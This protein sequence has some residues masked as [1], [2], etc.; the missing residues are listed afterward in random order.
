[1]QAVLKQQR[2]IGR[3]P[4]MQ[5][6]CTSA[7]GA[8][9]EPSFT[10]GGRFSGGP[11]E[12]WHDALAAQH[13][14]ESPAVHISGCRTEARPGMFAG[15]A[16]AWRADSGGTLP[17]RG[18]AC[19]PAAIPSAVMQAGE[20][21]LSLSQQ[22][23][24]RDSAESS[25]ATPA[26]AAEGQSPC[27]EPET[28]LSAAHAC[29]GAR[30]EREETPFFTPMAAI[31]TFRLSQPAA[32]S[33]AT[34]SN[35][36]RPFKHAC[37]DNTP[38]LSSRGQMSAAQP[39]SRLS[40]LSGPYGLSLEG[41][42]DQRTSLA[43]RGDSS[44]LL[45]SAGAGG[46]RADGSP[47]CLPHTDSAAA[48]ETA[49][50][51]SASKP[52]ST[53]CR[54]MDGT[55][56]GV[57]SISG[58][59]SWQSDMADWGTPGRLSEAQSS[60]PAHSRA[61][62][63]SAAACGAA[64]EDSASKPLGSMGCAWQSDMAERG[65][66]E[67]LPS[68]SEAQ[69][70]APDHSTS[71]LGMPAGH[72]AAELAMMSMR[73]SRGGHTWSSDMADWGSPG[74]LLAPSEAQNAAPDYSRHAHGTPVVQMAAELAPMSARTVS[75]MGKCPTLHL[76]SRQLSQQVG[77]CSAVGN[78]QFVQLEEGI[79][80]FSSARATCA[81]PPVLPRAGDVH[82][83]FSSALALCSPP[84]GL[85]E[86]SHQSS[87]AA[88]SSAALLRCGP[89]YST[90]QRDTSAQHFLAE[91]FSLT[92]SCASHSP[93]S[94]PARDCNSEALVQCSILLSAPK[95]AAG[96][97][98]PEHTSVYCSLPGEGSQASNSPGDP[99]ASDGMQ[100][101]MHENQDGVSMGPSQPYQ[102]PA[103][104]N[105]HPQSEGSPGSHGRSSHGQCQTGRIVR[106][107]ASLSGARAGNWVWDSSFWEA[108][109]R[110]LPGQAMPSPLEPCHDADSGLNITKDAG[111]GTADIASLEP[112]SLPI[113]GEATSLP[114]P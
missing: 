7:Q 26:S 91:G 71:V 34:L 97:S 17:A 52:P 108:P 38:L 69:S 55:A 111:N 13:D 30:G 3:T 93:K 27:L 84:L 61:A 103:I 81:R 11:P 70:S 83:S 88:Q 63:G 24:L 18:Q 42:L 15:Q 65:S 40:S 1:M 32:S 49:Q 41:G 8:D 2:P 114:S 44:G 73:S 112:A 101:R 110:A 67:R 47:Q 82:G 19:T 94:P 62:L 16:P 20:A 50:Q 90:P 104:T 43:E 53:F 46:L 37:S 100:R 106:S 85:S 45:D 51:K 92:S 80:P 29:S 25:E 10:L 58:S 23:E 96:A 56:D 9:P 86:R 107:R 68:F 4:A 60:A 78:P 48:W 72:V 98:L 75:S 76:P 113:P 21:C 64:E 6:D 109:A 54:G 12:E 57:S 95:D 22:T 33:T 14:D 102:T 79:H 105:E 99:P 35:L 36:S 66:P 87:L 28:G 5:Q 39:Q 59:S 31:P 74:G 77:S 89:P